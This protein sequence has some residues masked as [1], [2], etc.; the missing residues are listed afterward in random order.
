MHA[1]MQR[2]HVYLRSVTE[3]EVEHGVV[4]ERPALRPRRVFWLWRDIEGG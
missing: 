1:C 3:E 4:E 2:A